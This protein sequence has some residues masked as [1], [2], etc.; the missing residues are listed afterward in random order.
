MTRIHR[1]EEQPSI[2]I[3]EWA[4][5]TCSLIWAYDHEVPEYGYHRMTTTNP[6]SVVWL[7][8]N[9]E[10]RVKTQTNEFIVGPN[11][12][13]LLPEG[14]FWQDFTPKTQLLSLRFRACWATG[15]PLFRHREGRILQGGN[16]SKLEQTAR[17]MVRL[18]DQIHRR[19]KSTLRASITNTTQYFRLQRHLMTWLEVYA[20]ALMAEGFSPSRLNMLDPRIRDAAHKMDNWPLHIPFREE[21]LAKLVRISVRQLVRLFKNQFNQTPARYLHERKLQTAVNALK[22]DRETI[23]EIAFSLGFKSLT[24]FST[25]FRHNMH[26]SPR[27]FR[28][29]NL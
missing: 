16:H 29:K 6:E 1:F 19:S 25:W 18:Y 9:G 3:Q 14:D 24:H 4:S 27:D 26:T 23:K 13:C 11:T 7:I 8:R 21:E 5:L 17:P 20:D 10:A 28:K 15:I 12:W 22:S 2:A